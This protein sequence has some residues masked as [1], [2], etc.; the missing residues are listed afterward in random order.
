MKITKVAI[1]ELNNDKLKAFATITIDDEFVVTGL[2]V[3][4]SVNGYFV[5][6]PSRKNTKENTNNDPNYKSYIDTS[7]P[8][9]KES[10]K[11]IEDEVLQAYHNY[12]QSNEPYVEPPRNE[13]NQ[14]RPSIEV[15]SDMLPF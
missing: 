5:G 14:E 1:H 15:D 10:R 12:M 3:L 9:T 8:I 6:Y 4:D 11:Y 2:K 7:F 13:Q